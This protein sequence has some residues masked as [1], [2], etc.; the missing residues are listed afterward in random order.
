MKRIS[1][2]NLLKLKPTIFGLSIREFFILGNLM[3][4]GN[5]LIEDHFITLCSFF[6]IYGGILLAKKY[7]QPCFFT[8]I[9]KK[10]EILPYEIKRN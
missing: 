5:L 1:L 10:K 9:F 6:P 2:P 4:L 3:V 8:F 7:L